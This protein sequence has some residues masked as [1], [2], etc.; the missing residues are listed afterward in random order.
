[1]AFADAKG[2]GAGGVFGLL[3]VTHERFEAPLAMLL[4]NGPAWSREEP[5]LRKLVA[6]LCV[7]LSRIAVR[8]GKLGR[9]L[10][11][12]TTFECLVDW[13]TSYGLPDCAQPTTLEG[14]RAAISAKLIA[15]LGHDQNLEFWTDLLLKLGYTL[16]WVNKAHA[17]M[18]VDDDVLD[19]LWEDEWEA[20]WELVVAHGLD[21]ALLECVVNHQSLI[22]TLPIVHFLWTL[23][24][25]GEVI[26]IYALASD[27]AGF[28]VACGKSGKVLYVGA[29]IDDDDEW[30]MA[31]ALPEDIFAACSVGTV[32]LA[33]GVGGVNF[34]RSTDGGANWTQV[35]TPTDE[36]YGLSRGPADD[37]VAVAVGENGRIWRTPDAGLTWAEQTSPTTV[38]LHAVTRATA[39]LV[40]VGDSGKVIRSTNNGTTWTLIA[41]GITAHL[42]GVGGWLLVFVAVGAGGQIWR[43][44]N[45]GANWTQ[46]TSPVTSALRAVARSGTGRWTAAGDD[47]VILQSLDDGLTWKVQESPTTNDLLAVVAHFPSGRAIA[48]GLT[49]TIVTE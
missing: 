10:D 21:D 46:I 42:Y 47:G 32:L 48:G 41:A 22:E 7:E 16:A 8:E 19:L 12:S 3:D 4:P 43:S 23:L 33:A 29:Q 26:D 39:A 18:T 2:I 11:P 17:V 30:Q 40:A 31:T 1:M 37:L 14:R 49:T 44:S 45:S 27:D 13:E 28:T 24:D 36:M 34:H 15:Q 38:V 20:V 9:E 5:T 35:D 6:A 25:S